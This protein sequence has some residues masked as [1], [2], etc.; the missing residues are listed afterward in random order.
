MSWQRLGR[1]HSGSTVLCKHIRD[2]RSLFSPSYVAKKSRSRERLHFGIGRGW[3][4]LQSASNSLLYNKKRWT[5]WGYSWGY[6][7]QSC[8]NEEKNESG[9]G[10]GRRWVKWGAVSKSYL[11]T[12]GL[13]RFMPKSCAK[14]SLFQYILGLTGHPQFEQLLK[15]VYLNPYTYTFAGFDDKDALFFTARVGPSHYRES[16]CGV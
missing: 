3:P 11:E 14:R 1:R 7:I 13:T 15:S 6:W 12:L 9:V 5:G 16:F 10:S 2:F 4:R 8:Q